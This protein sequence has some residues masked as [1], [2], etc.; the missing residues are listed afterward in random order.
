[1]KQLLQNI[2]AVILAGGKN[3]RFNGK[4]KSLAFFHDK[5]ILERQIMV[6]KSLFP[7][8]YL[9]TNHFHDFQK[10]SELEIFEDI[11]KDKGPLGG[12]HAGITYSGEE[13]IFVFAGDM[14][15]LDKKLIEKQVQMHEK[16]N[17]SVT[18]PKTKKGIEPLHGIYNK[19]LKKELEDLLYQQDVF[20]IRA[21]FT[22][23]NTYFWRLEYNKA[24]ININSQEELAFYEK[25]WNHTLQRRKE[26][27][28][29]G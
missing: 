2:D 26:R 1:L 24:F 15:F 11:I 5:T 16:M 12:I 13:N 3:R 19:K 8:I 29:S 25:N 23:S 28:S 10:F 27:K 18:I 20:S 7:K 22:P 21:L 4:H 6:L 14:P 17:F 9:I